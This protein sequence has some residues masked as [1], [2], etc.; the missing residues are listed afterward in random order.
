M[1]QKGSELTAEDSGLRREGSELRTQS[2]GLRAEV[3]GLRVEGSDVEASEL[4]SEQRQGC[5]GW[6]AG[7]AR[8]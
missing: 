5:L 6:Q 8:S 1:L 3:P 2:C 4:R 7:F